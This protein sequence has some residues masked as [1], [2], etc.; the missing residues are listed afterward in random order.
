M[1]KRQKKKKLFCQEKNIRK[2]CYL[3]I[4][5]GFFFSFYDAFP[6]VLDGTATHCCSLLYHLQLEEESGHMIFEH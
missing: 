2:I 1:K 5:F 6:F 3:F 4:M